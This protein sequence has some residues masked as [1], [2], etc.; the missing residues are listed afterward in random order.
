MVLDRRSPWSEV[1]DIVGELVRRG[2]ERRSG[3]DDRGHVRTEAVDTERG[4]SDPLDAVTEICCTLD[5]TS[6]C[7]VM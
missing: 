6:G 7:E 1:C 5:G 4:H 2:V 3:G